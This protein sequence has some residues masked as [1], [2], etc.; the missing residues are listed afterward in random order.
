M[1]ASIARVLSLCVTAVLVTGAAAQP[2]ADSKEAL[3][4]KYEAICEELKQVAE[5]Y[6]NAPPAVRQEAMRRWREQN[7][8]RIQ[9]VELALARIAEAEIAAMPEPQPQT[10]IVPAG[11]SPDLREL[12][13]REAELNTER[14]HLQWQHRMAPAERRMRAMQLWDTANA[15]RLDELEEL[16]RKLAPPPPP[17]SEIVISIPREATALEREYWHE[18]AALLEETLEI[19]EAH[20]G[21]PV[22]RLLAALAAW[23]QRNGP[24]LAAHRQMASDLQQ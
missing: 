13:V 3:I 12:L 2:P 18:E 6:R 22:A 16:R 4:R 8:D 24:R 17:A 14:A 23:E 11:A 15:A 10:A 7:L 21:Q 19:R 5:Q 20:E 1:D 9:P